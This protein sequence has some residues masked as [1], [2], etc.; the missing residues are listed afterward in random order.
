MRRLRGRRR[1]RNREA[2]QRT[3]ER[4]LRSRGR[5]KTSAPGNSAAMRA[6]VSSA[7]FRLRA[8]ST[9]RAPRIAS[10]RAVSAPIPDVAP[11][12]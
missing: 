9:S 1:E 3:E 11:A 2:K 7:A 4:E 8:G 5:T 10:T 6:F 12:Q